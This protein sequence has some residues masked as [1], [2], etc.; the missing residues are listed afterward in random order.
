MAVHGPGLYLAAFAAALAVS[1]VASL[2][3]VYGAVL[4]PPLP[5][6]FSVLP[7][8]GLH[9]RTSVQRGRH[10][11]CPLPLLASGAD[12]RSSHSPA[13]GRHDPRCRRRC[14]SP[15]WSFSRASR[16]EMVIAVVVIWLGGGSPRTQDLTTTRSARKASLRPLRTRDRAH[17]LSRLGSRRITRSRAS[18]GL[19]RTDQQWN[20]VAALSSVGTARPPAGDWWP[21]L[22]LRRGPR[23]AA[24]PVLLIAEPVNFVDGGEIGCLGAGNTQRGYV[25]EPREAGQSRVRHQHRTRRPFGHR[26]AH[27]FCHTDESFRALRRYERRGSRFGGCHRGRQ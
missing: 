8:L 24:V 20:Q 5:D 13:A 19:C 14:R 22:F 7:A 15:E 4:V 6:L 11:G 21:S 3:G 23:K 16:L 17:P 26:A 1:T 12:R 27:C 25:H 10:T 18:S 2:A 9:P